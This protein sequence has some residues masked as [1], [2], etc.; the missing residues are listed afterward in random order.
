MGFG[1][2]NRWRWRDLQMSDGEHYSELM[3]SHDEDCEDRL[4]Y[5]SGAAS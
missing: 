5:I 1:S 4:L 2:N 3:A